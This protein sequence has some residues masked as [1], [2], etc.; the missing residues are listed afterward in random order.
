MNAAA[1]KYTRDFGL[2]M[3]VY[4]VVTLF[5]MPIATDESLSDALRVTIVLT[6]IVPAL[7]AL[8]AVLTFYRATDELNQKIVGEAVIISFL[9]TGLL[10][11]A[12]GFVE[13]IGFP[14]LPVI[15]ILPFSIAV[16]GIALKFV[17]GRY[18]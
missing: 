17:S 14:K 13:L 16:W 4:S 11:F 7:F 9:I 10:T 8:R 15:A 3:T 18:K 5:L 1:K 12:Y 6:P 2:A